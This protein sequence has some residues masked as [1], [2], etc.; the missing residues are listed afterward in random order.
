M[1][2]KAVLAQPSSWITYAISSNAFFALHR[3]EVPLV[4][5]TRKK[6]PDIPQHAVCHPFPNGCGFF[7]QN[8]HPGHVQWLIQL[9]IGH[10]LIEANHPP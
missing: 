2:Y 3:A 5:V 9:D 1:S 6:I 8:I 4:L 7:G 10:R